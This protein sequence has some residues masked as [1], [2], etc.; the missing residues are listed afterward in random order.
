MNVRV[1]GAVGDRLIEVRTELIP[2]GGPFRLEGLPAAR[3]RTTAD[4]VRAALVNTG[5]LRELP[6]A[7]VHL[8]PSVKGDGTSELDLPIALAL[9]ARTGAV[10]G[11]RWILAGGRLGLDGRVHAVDLEMPASI[12]TVV[13]ELCGVHP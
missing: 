10:A 8:H 9:L 2:E 4:R 1:W 6:P 7:A 5:L 13:T 11:V 3:L 12:V